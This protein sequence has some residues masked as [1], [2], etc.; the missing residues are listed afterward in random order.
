MSYVYLTELPHGFT[1]RKATSSPPPPILS[2]KGFL[3]H[4]RS[5]MG[6]TAME[7]PWISYLNDITAGREAISRDRTSK[8]LAKILLDTLLSTAESRAADGAHRIDSC[9]RDD[10]ASNPLLGILEGKGMNPC[11]HELYTLVFD[12]ACLIPYLDPIQDILVQ[13]IVELHKLPPK[14]RTISDVRYTLPSQ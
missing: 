8:S 13:L 3:G 6:N 4:D 12:T 1:S 11:L 9:F 2:K 5:R 7:Q 14:P 10:A